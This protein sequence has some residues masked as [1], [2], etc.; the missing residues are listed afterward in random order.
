MSLLLKLVLFGLAGFGLI[1][2]N[3]DAIEYNNSIQQCVMNYKIIDGHFDTFKSENNLREVCE[4]LCIAY[5]PS[6][7]KNGQRILTN[8]IE[9][10]YQ[11]DQEENN[12]QHACIM[13]D[14]DDRYKKQC[15]HDF[16]RGN[17]KK[18][19]EYFKNNL[20]LRPHDHRRGSK[21]ASKTLK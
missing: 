2:H 20:P 8:N 6:Y 19:Q 21:E 1:K 10:F 3:N 9:E 14:Y 11:M 18:R 17:I 7:D 5:S 16:E 15:E 12:C 4:R 13:H